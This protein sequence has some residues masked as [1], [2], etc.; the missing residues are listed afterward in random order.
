MKIVLSILIPSLFRRDYLRE[1]LARKVLRQAEPYDDIEVLAWV[2]NK[3]RSIGRKRDDLVQMASG[4]FLVILDDDDDISDDYVAEL[5]KA[6]IENPSVDVIVFD[7]LCQLNDWAPFK[8][9]FGIE[10]ENQAAADGGGKDI[11]RKPFH[12]C[13]WRSDLAKS[14]RFPDHSYGED[15]EWAAQLWPKITQ[16][17]RID[18]VLHTYRWSKEITEAPTEL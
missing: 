10:F 11:T 16:Q 1:T 4:D 3:K 9:R 12:V 14:A 8:V 17:H 7:Q 13:C 18:K 5:R 2:D 15:A 6:A